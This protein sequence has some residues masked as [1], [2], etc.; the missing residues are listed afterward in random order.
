M[1]RNLQKIIYEWPANITRYEAAV[2]MGLTTNEAVGGGL[3]F[4]ACLM[5]IP[6]KL[7]GGVLGAVV[8]VV[9][10]LS[11]KKLE[12]FLWSFCPSRS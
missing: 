7:L 11:I 6:N 1:N 2:F 10:V 4:M 12:R 5:L 3:A 9:V 8:A